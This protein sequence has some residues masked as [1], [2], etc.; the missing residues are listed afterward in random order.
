MDK[1][2]KQQAGYLYRPETRY[3]CGE[4]VFQKELPGGKSGCAFFGPGETISLTKGSC[5]YFSHGHRPKPEVPWLGVWTKLELGY[6]ESPH[7]FSCKR[8]EEFIVGENACKKVDKDS[9]GDTPGTISPNGCCSNWEADP[10]RGKLSDEAL[11]QIL[12]APIPP[13]PEDDKLKKMFQ[14]MVTR[15]R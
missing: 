4:C 13:R 6:D 3:V 1:L 12:A 14:G 7:G 9:E 11:V 5:N 2:D 15:G 8:C 10:R